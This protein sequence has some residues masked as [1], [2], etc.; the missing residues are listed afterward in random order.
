ILRGIGAAAVALAGAVVVFS[1]TPA[2]GTSLHTGLDARDVDVTTLS[3]VSSAGPLARVQ[4]RVGQAASTWCGTPAQQDL[5]PN[6][7]AGDA[8]HWL[9]VVPSDGGDRFSATSSAMQTDAEL[10]D[11]WWRGQDATRAPRSDTA[12]FSCGVQLD[13]SDVRLSQSS[14]QLDNDAR[15]ERI[16]DGV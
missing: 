11:T 10:I 1:G 4:P 7:V 8:V 5:S 2:S 9:Y 12:P 3:R 16:V 14:S 6:A 15:F 13:V